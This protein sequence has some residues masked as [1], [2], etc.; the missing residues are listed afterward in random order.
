[1]QSQSGSHY[2]RPI[3]LLIRRLLS[4]DYCERTQMLQSDRC[5]CVEHD[6]IRMAQTAQASDQRSTVS[7]NAILSLRSHVCY[8]Q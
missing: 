1:M 6:H 3:H 7:S 4:A 2:S 5:A 8:L